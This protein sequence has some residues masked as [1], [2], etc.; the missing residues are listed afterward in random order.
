VAR[1]LGDVL[2]H[3][4]PALGPAAEPSSPTQAEPRPEPG[5]VQLLA[6][7]M[8]AAD[9]LRGAI[10]W[11]LALELGRAGAT[12][13][14]V[15]PPDA[16]VPEE[17]A[18]LGVRVSGAHAADWVR[19]TGQART[20]L[21]NRTTLDAPGLLLAGLAAEA[22]PAA[23][24]HTD[25]ALLC[26]ATEPAALERAEAQGRRWLE[27]GHDRLGVVIHGAGSLREARRAFERLAGPLERVA[28]QPIASFGL[29]VDDLALYRSLVERRPVGL[30]RPQS[31]AGRALADVARLLLAP[32]DSP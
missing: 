8:E 25:L 10:V 19:A 6:V 12:V 30:T 18:T 22:T 29:L 5:P 17:D 13:E 28:G 14:A 11:N 2:H 27:A 3:F 16:G 24:E 4:D 21:A 9:L 20:R 1:G 26:C 31:P 15:I 32:E 23:A 7:P